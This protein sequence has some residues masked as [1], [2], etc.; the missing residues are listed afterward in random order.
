MMVSYQ[1]ISFLMFAALL[2]PDYHFEANIISE[3]V[4]LVLIAC[5]FNFF[6]EV[7]YVYA[8]YNYLETFLPEDYEPQY[9]MQLDEE[10]K[11]EYWSGSYESTDKSQDNSKM[12]A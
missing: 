7:I 3:A 11:R 12:K 1:L 2:F 5:F 8:H 9:N 6:K 10:E 4:L